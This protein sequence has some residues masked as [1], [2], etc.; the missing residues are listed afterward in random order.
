MWGVLL[1]GSGRSGARP[2]HQPLGVCVSELSRRA[3]S[4]PATDAPDQKALSRP[5]R[6]FST[7]SAPGPGR[8]PRPPAQHAR[9]TPLARPVAPVCGWVG[10][11]FESRPR[12]RT[13]A[14]PGELGLVPAPGPCACG[15]NKARPACSPHACKTAD[16]DPDQGAYVRGARRAAR[17]HGYEFSWP[18]PRARAPHGALRQIRIWSSQAEGHHIMRT[19]CYI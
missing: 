12:H 8:C 10:L 7:P 4:S 3:C 9:A 6:H 1:C 11:S 5:L 16:P 2:R 15:G 13:R 14:R 17:G 19:S 18:A